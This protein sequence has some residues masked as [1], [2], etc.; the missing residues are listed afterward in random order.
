LE[1]GLGAQTLNQVGHQIHT[2]LLRKGCTAKSNTME[3][4]GTKKRTG[5][6]ERRLY[7]PIQPKIRKLSETTSTV[8]KGKEK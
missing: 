2:P 7:C 4:G 6:A 3:R 1:K 5:Q 8:A